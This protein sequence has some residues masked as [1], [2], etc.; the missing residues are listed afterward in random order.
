MNSGTEPRRP[1]FRGLLA[2]FAVVYAIGLACGVG[3]DRYWLAPVV[4]AQTAPKT[5]REQFVGLWL[6]EDGSKTEFKSDGT[7]DETFRETVP[8]IKPGEVVDDPAKL[9]MVERVARVTGQYDWVE[10]DKIQVRIPGKPSR[11]LKL[12]VEGESLTILEED[13]RVARLKRSK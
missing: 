8:D 7:F 12:V 2:G 1:S 13:G 3:L 11:R 9:R 6:A 10:V 4:P 5:L